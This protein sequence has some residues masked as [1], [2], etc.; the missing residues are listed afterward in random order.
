MAKRRQ[1]TAP[2]NASLVVILTNCNEASCSR[3]NYSTNHK[4]PFQIITTLIPHSSISEHHSLLPPRN[5]K[6]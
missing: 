4:W 2:A 5:R 1:W 3:N 6:H